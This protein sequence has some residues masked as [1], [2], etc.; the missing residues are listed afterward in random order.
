MKAVGGGGAKGGDGVDELAFSAGS[1]QFGTR[2]ISSNSAVYPHSLLVPEK[3]AC[4]GVEYG[5]D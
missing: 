2:S 3:R 4:V 5:S 1:V